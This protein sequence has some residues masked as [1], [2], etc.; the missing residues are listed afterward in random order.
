MVYQDMFRVRPYPDKGRIIHCMHRI[1]GFRFNRS[2]TQANLR[3]AQLPSSPGMA[4]STTRVCSERWLIGPYTSMT[5]SRGTRT[6]KR[7]T[8]RAMRSC[9]CKHAYKGGKE[10]RGGEGNV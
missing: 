6:A 9:P 5:S 4:K 3:E 8:L 2:L 1:G 10:A 7:K